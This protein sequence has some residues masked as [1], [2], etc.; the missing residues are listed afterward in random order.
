M[1]Q[2]R[3]DALAER[4]EAAS[5]GQQVQPRQPQR[6]HRPPLAS[7][8][9]HAQ[10][11][12][13]LRGWA[14]SEPDPQRQARLNQAAELNEAFIQP[15]R[16]NQQPEP[17]ATERHTPQLPRPL[18]DLVLDANDS[19]GL[20]AVA[21]PKPDLEGLAKH[22]GQ[23]L[24]RRFGRDLAELARGHSRELPQ[25]FEAFFRLYLLTPSAAQRMAPTFYGAFDEFLDG[26]DPGLLEALDGIQRYTEKYGPK[27]HSVRA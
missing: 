21:S 4:H 11:A 27:G 2:A 5:H 7:P 9:E 26:E 25:G 14:A 22:G 24:S 3:L 8:E 12:R 1:R 18:A 15:P 13:G 10:M 23:A 20:F 19:L 16:L 6:Q 17:P